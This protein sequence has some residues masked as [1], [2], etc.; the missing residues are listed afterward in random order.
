M[1]LT[2]RMLKRIVEQEMAKSRSLDKSDVSADEVDA[3]EFADSLE[4]KVDYVKALKLEQRRLQK[5]LQ[6]ISEEKSRVIKS[7]TR[8]L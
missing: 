6:R 1:R 2:S 4:N 3:D 5:R 8:S 7:I